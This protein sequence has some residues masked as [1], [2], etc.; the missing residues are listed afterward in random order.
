MQRHSAGSRQS[1]RRYSW[2]F[3]ARQRLTRRVRWPVSNNCGLGINGAKDRQ[4]NGHALPAPL[5]IV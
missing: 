4:F 5:A 2:L 1:S 3:A